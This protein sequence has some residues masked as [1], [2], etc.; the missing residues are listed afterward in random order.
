MVLGG[1][2]KPVF[3]TGWERKVFAIVEGDDKDTGL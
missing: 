2:T 3:R 1:A